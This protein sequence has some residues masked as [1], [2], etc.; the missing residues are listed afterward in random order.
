MK[1]LSIFIQ[2]PVLA[3]VINILIVLVGLVAY[4]KLTI[5]EYPNIDL[6]V[7]S[8]VTT[9]K[10]ASAY[11]MESQ[12]TDVLEES[13]SGIDGVDFIASK[14]RLGR[15]EISVHFEL[16]R[17][18]DAA[19][20][21]VRDRVARVRNLLPDDIDEPIMAKVEAGAAPFMYLALTSSS[22]EPAQVNDIAE[23]EIKDALQ[24]IAGVAEI[25][26]LGAR[27]YAMRVLLMI[28]SISMLPPLGIS[29]L[30]NDGAELAFIAGF[31]IT[32]MTG[33]FIWIPVYRV[34]QDL[35]TRDGFLITVSILE[36]TGACSGPSR[37]CL[38]TTHI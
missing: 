33:F 21:D 8:V 32:L 15:S 14:S 16:S 11:I 4:S 12:V 36:R 6:P 28:F 26:I 38:Q 30:Y 1:S 34:R 37:L 25:R 7:V 22:R 2:R 27:R 29:Y 5:R 10:G 31:L 18:A 35:R 24:T 13:L 20:S 19:A 9:Y 17:D 23:N 3:T